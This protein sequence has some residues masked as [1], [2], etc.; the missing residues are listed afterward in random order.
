MAQAFMDKESFESTQMTAIIIAAGEY[1]VSDREWAVA[2][3][4]RLNLDHCHQNEID[5]MTLKAKWQQYTNQILPG[6]GMDQLSISAEQRHNK[7][8]IQG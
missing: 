7:T 5:E 3:Y 6:M 1:F 2:I 4:A 8:E